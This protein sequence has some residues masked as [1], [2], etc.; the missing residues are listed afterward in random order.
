[1]SAVKDR[2]ISLISESETNGLDVLQILRNCAE[3]FSTSAEEQDKLNEFSELFRYVNF[4][5]FR[6]FVDM[7]YEDRL[8]SNISNSL[9]AFLVL[10]EDCKKMLV[11]TH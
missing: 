9:K 2:F 1:M 4:V 8:P 3:E 6:E 11:K 7:V 10:L 5:S